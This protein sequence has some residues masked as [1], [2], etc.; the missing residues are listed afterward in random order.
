M[1]KRWHV[2]VWRTLRGTYIRGSKVS[3]LLSVLR[4]FSLLDEIR[5]MCIMKPKDEDLAALRQLS[6]LRELTLEINSLK[7][8]SCVGYAYLCELPSLVHLCLRG[9]YDSYKHPVLIYYPRHGYY[10]FFSF[11]P[12]CEY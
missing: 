11:P 3:L 4:S 7:P 8:P 2:L 12:S 1:S 10:F 9:L 5:F 6:F